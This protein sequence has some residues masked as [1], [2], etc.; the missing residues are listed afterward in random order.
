MIG[1]FGSFIPY[2]I[3]K[4]SGGITAGQHL[5]ALEEYMEVLYRKSMTNSTQGANSNFTGFI[6]SM[7]FFDQEGGLRQHFSGYFCH[8]FINIS[9]FIYLRYSAPFY[10]LVVASPFPLR[11]SQKVFKV[12]NLQPV[13]PIFCLLLIFAEAPWLIGDV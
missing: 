6:G 3:F 12:P 5:L 8:R 9:G 1:F 7:P 4:E 10:D 13:F 11:G 2:V